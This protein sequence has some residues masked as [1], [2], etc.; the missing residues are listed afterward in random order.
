MRGFIIKTQDNKIIRFK[1]YL[2]EA[3]VTS[4]A[5]AKLLPFTRMFFHARV[6][7]QEIWI[8]N[9]PQLDIIQENASVFTEP[10]EV[11]FG[12]LKPKRTKTSNCM[13][14]YYGE[15]KGLDCCNIFAKVFEEDMNLLKM[16]GDNIWKF[17]AQELTFEKL[18]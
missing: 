4:N 15:G 11:V 2:E 9:T 5:F 14:I 7:G 18:D 16:L 3:P 17:G 13:G 1:F 12:P 8:D 10:G 6:S